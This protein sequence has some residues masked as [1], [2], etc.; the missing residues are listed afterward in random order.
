MILY[1]A[2]GLLVR[3]YGFSSS[4]K[5]LH[6]SMILDLDTARMGVFPSLQAEILKSVNNS[7]VGLHLKHFLDS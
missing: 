2:F 5:P 4:W 7:P 3:V 1:E 6:F